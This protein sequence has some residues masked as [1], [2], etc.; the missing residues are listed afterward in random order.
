[1]G[2]GG[3]G[4]GGPNKRLENAQKL[5]RMNRKRKPER[6]FSETKI[7]NGGKFKIVKCAEFGIERTSRK[8]SGNSLEK[9]CVPKSK[10]NRTESFPKCAGEQPT[11]PVK[12]AG[13]PTNVKLEKMPENVQKSLNPTKDTKLAE[14]PPKYKNTNVGTSKVVK[15]EKI[16]LLENRVDIVGNV[17][18]VVV[19]NNVV[20]PSF[21]RIQVEEARSSPVEKKE[22]G[23]HHVEIEVRSQKRKRLEEILKTALARKSSG[24]GGS[25]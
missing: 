11:K 3:G 16:N 7:I 24:M 5:T 18:V 21:G 22:A 14:R 13:M 23:S 19:R 1:M 9:T 2:G 12:L 15:F 17:E 6:I 10:N 20:K 25:I 4:A 8:V